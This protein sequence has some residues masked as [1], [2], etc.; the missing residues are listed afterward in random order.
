MSKNDFEVFKAKNRRDKIIIVRKNAPYEMHG[1]VRKETTAYKLIDLIVSHEMPESEY[2]VECMKRLLYEDE[3]KA[4]QRKE[5]KQKCV[6][7]NHNKKARY[8]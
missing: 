3:F 4:I 6:K 7:R 1:H 8:A 2:L 5:K